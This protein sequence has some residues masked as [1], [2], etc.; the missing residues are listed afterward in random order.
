MHSEGFS[1][2]TAHPVVEPD[3]RQE[4]LLVAEGLD[5]VHVGRAEGRI[6][7]EDNPDET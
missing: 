3:E 4:T 2:H 1:Y 6:D 5:G 7:A